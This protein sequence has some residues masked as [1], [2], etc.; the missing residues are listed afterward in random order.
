[1]STFA[2]LNFLVIIQYTVKCLIYNP[3][4]VII[5]VNECFYGRVI[6]VLLRYLHDRTVLCKLSP[7]FKNSAVLDADLQEKL[8]KQR[9]FGLRCFENEGKTLQQIGRKCI[10]DSSYKIILLS[11]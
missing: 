1:M 9:M 10:F 2:V 4:C 7:Y 11:F 3:E 6:S 8:H 5:N